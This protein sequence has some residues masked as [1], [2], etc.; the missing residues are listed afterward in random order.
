MI[1]KNGTLFHTPSIKK[2]SNKST[3]VVFK[4][5]TLFSRIGFEKIPLVPTVTAYG[6]KILSITASNIS[7]FIGVA[8]AQIDKVIGAE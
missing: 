2:D 4:N 6:Q 8:R 1:F 3:K 5:G 7:K